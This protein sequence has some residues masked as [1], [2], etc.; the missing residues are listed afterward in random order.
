L[1]IG[2]SNFVFKTASFGGNVTV[3]NDSYE[4]I[5]RIEVTS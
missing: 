3:V 4:I 1:C 2:Y 5:G